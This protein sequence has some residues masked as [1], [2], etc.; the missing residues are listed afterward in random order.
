MTAIEK[1]NSIITSVDTL[2]QVTDDCNFPA[3][4]AIYNAT[5]SGRIELFAR[6]DD[7]K[8]LADAVYSPLHT[9]TSYNHIGDDVYKTTEMWFCYKDHIFTMIREEKYNG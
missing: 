6:E 1:L 3:V 9:V 8:A 5:A 7:F 2:A 4:R